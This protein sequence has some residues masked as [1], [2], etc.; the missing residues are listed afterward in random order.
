MAGSATTGGVFQ[1]AS[2]WVGRATA[3][4]LA[5][6]WMALWA[7]L[8]VATDEVLE[9]V[10]LL[11]EGMLRSANPPGLK[12]GDVELAHEAL[13]VVTFA[14]TVIMALLT[15]ERLTRFGFAPRGAG[16]DLLIGVSTGLL[17]MLGTLA[18][19]AALGGFAF[20]RVAIPADRIG[21]QA[22]KY[23]LLFVLV[24]L[25]EELWFRSFVLV[26]LSRAV[27]FWP[28]A[29]LMSGLFLL[30]HT[31][32]IGENPLGLLAASLVGLV[33]AY[34]FRRTGAL[35]FAIGFHAAW[36]YAES[37]LFGVP[38]SG[39]V[40]P[41]A[42]MRPTL[43]GPAWLTGGPTGPEGS[44]LVYAVLLILALVV[45]FALPRREA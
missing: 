32:N 33:L 42:L 40:L 4:G 35:W 28:A 45:R 39:S 44:L 24:A 7:A 6:A 21:M 23:A 38:D 36:D 29:L 13:A 17:L 26:Q 14:A 19:M 5:V 9:H 11:P 16:R 43:G 1:R 10:G 27:S 30:S 2:T 3:F 25:T 15:R 37:F 18:L 34:S 8:L 22:A 41:G 12:P 20:G 31:A